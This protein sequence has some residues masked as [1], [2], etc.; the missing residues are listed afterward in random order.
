VQY[1][2]RVP[3]KIP[4]QL[5]KKISPFS[6]KIH[7]IPFPAVQE[8]SSRDVA[9]ATGDE[10][11]RPFYKYET[12]LDA[13]E[14]VI[15]DKAKET[16]DRVTLVK[17]LR[18]QYGQLAKS[19]KVAAQITSL[20]QDNTFTIVTAH[21]PSLFTGPLY[22]IIKICSTINLVRQLRERY[23]EQNFVPV[24]I[25]GGEDHDFEEINHLHLY[26]NKIEWD[27]EEEGAV[28][29]MST[30]TL[31]APLAALKDVLGDSERAQAVFEELQAAYTRHAHYG[32][33]TVDYVHTLFAEEGLV[34]IDMNKVALKRLLIPIMKEE[35]VKQPSQAYIEKAQLELEKAGFSGQAHAREINLFYLRDGLRERIV[36]ENDTYR[37]LN[38][39]YRFTQEQLLTEL[40]AHPDFFSPNVIMRPLYQ[41]KVLPNLAYIGGGGELAYWLERKEQFAHFGINFPMLIRR[42]SLLWLDSGTVKRMNKLELEVADLFV[43]TEALL[44]QFV[45]SQT[46]N[47][48][49]IQEEKEQLEALFTSI[50]DKARDI[51]PTLAKAIEAEYTR[52][53]KSVDNLE[54]R[55]MRAEKQKHENALNQIRKL[56]EKLF[57]NNGLQERYDNFLT[58]YLRQGHGFFTT[59]ID[60]LDPLQ[61][62]F[63][64]VEE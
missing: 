24:F 57:P 10:R 28:G 39:D 13:F 38:T 7:H 27:N 34:V 4:H 54:G 53:A 17:A 46:D 11:L 15:A 18:E 49:T 9:Y 31:D 36:L 26:G 63:V 44:K 59:L 16:I 22:F 58:F 41:E 51:D 60:V 19:E 6:M 20:E 14:Q 56:K 45:S 33:A 50:A 25:T 32:L 21:Q 55:L 62:G 23:P 35:L 3:A 29:Q 37:V 47:E 48:L 8:L 2:L 30:S 40:E 61:E 42:N 5:A 43:E 52:Q 1:Y 12:N 64:V